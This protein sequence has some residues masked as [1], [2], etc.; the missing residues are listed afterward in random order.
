MA[1]VLAAT[2]QQLLELQKQAQ[3]FQAYAAR[4]SA[5]VSQRYQF[6]AALAAN[7]ARNNLS[8]SD[9]IGADLVAAND[10]ATRN[11]VRWATAVVA[12]DK[13]T[14][15]LA[16]WTPDN[17]AT[18]RLGVVVAGTIPQPLG[19]WPIVPILYYGAAAIASVGTWLLADAWL[20][21]N[22]I[23]AEAQRT[24]AATQK[25]ATDAIAKAAALGPQ[26]G[27]M[28]A[29]AIAQANASAKAPPQS[30]LQ[31]LAQAIASVGEGVKEAAKAGGGFGGIALVFAAIYFGSKGRSRASA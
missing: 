5:V 31:S 6:T 19:V 1:Q 9:A 22:A 30:T 12:L 13:R 21:A 15:E 7:A 18:I 4:V 3:Q 2:Q 29:D 20:D 25:A 10:Q 23:E 11:A 27:Q 26:Y 17:G 28:V 14:A 24:Y 8:L 16:A